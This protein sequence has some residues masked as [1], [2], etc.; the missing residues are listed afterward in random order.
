[1]K[2]NVLKEIEPVYRTDRD[3]EM[4]MV[5]EFVNKYKPKSLLDVGCHFSDHTYAPIIRPHIKRYDGIDILP[6]DMALL[7]NYYVGNVLDMP[8]EK[9]ECVMCISTLEHVGLSTYE[10]DHDIEMTKVFDRCVSLA[11]KAVLFTFPVGAGERIDD[12]METV[13][14]HQFDKM[15]PHSKVRYFYTQGSP[16]GHKWIEHD[17][18]QFAFSVPYVDFIG[19]Q[20]LMVLEVLL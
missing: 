1:M 10:A 13:N 19:T 6:S 3:V 2:L 14:I 20:S 5:C 11:T 12:E 7:D 18:Q 17:N 15:L 8:L 4:P 9:Y 16:A